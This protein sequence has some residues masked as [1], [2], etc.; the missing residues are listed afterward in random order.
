[1]VIIRDMREYDNCRLGLPL[2]ENL[3]SCYD[4]LIEDLSLIKP[5]FRSHH[6]PVPYIYLQYLGSLTK[7]QV[8]GMIRAVED[9]SY[10]LV[11]SV[12]KTLG[13]D[14]YPNGKYAQNLSSL[15][16]KISCPDALRAFRSWSADALPLLYPRK[17]RRHLLREN[18]S[19]HQN[20]STPAIKLG[21]LEGEA[22][23][24]LTAEEIELLRLRVN[25]VDWTF[26]VTAVSFYGIDTALSSDELKI[27]TSVPIE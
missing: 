13:F 23:E 10:T 12:V 9:N 11:G 21:K 14:S 17:P 20:P 2:P 26:P 1:M 3:L 4:A 5:G 7:E 15:L 16:L 8:V 22:R 27:L 24:S 6:A 18:G 25:A 19:L